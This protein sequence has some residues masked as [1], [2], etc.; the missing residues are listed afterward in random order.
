[1]TSVLSV[2]KIDP[3][4]LI[5]ARIRYSLKSDTDAIQIITDNC[6]R[7]K[8]IY[9]G[10]FNQ[11]YWTSEDRETLGVIVANSMVAD[12]VRDGMLK[13]L[14]FCDQQC[15]TES[16][17]HIEIIDNLG[18]FLEVCFKNQEKKKFKD[19]VQRILRSYDLDQIKLLLRLC[20][21][22]SQVLGLAEFS[23]AELKSPKADEAFMYK[24]CF[25][26]LRDT[27]KLSSMPRSSKLGRLAMAQQWMAEYIEKGKSDKPEK[28]EKEK[29]KEKSEAAAK[30]KVVSVDPSIKARNNHGRQM[31]KA[32]EEDEEEEDDEEDE[33]EDDEEED[34]E[35]E[36]DEEDD[37]ESEDENGQGKDGEDDDDGRDENDEEDGEEDDEDGD[38]NENENANGNDKVE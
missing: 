5:A 33:E 28:K 32:K 26:F 16:K 37:D 23:S 27:D 24:V 3:K 38:E 7:L 12:S 20:W 18:V 10:G 1:M 19:L 4:T 34:D 14:E 15:K 8:S 11:M 35:E 13:D 25:E 29:E 9:E 30:E 31:V 17:G 6:M 21:A 36:D 22:C 2:D